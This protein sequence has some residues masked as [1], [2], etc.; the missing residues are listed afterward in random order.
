MSKSKVSKA[1]PPTG[2]LKEG[3]SDSNCAKVNSPQRVPTQTTSPQVASDALKVNGNSE[4]GTAGLA[5][6]EPS[7]TGVPNLELTERVKELLR[8]AQDQGHLTYNDINDA[9]PDGLASAEEIEDVLM[10]LRN[11]EVEIVDQAEV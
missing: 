9:L 10:K 1:A 3:S 7:Q 5:N 6:G 11:L 8:L 2:A 4:K